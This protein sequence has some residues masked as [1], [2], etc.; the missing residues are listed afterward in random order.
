MTVDKMRFAVLTKAKVAEVHER[1]LPEMDENQILIKQEACNICTT[2]YGQWL[3]LREH[4]PYPMAGGHEGA[5]VIVKKG[6]K[7]RDDLNI[8]DRVAVTYGYCGECGPCKSGATSECTQ[9]ESGPTEDGYYGNFGFADYC[10]RDS[11]VLIK[12]DKGLSASEASF[13]EPLATVAKGLRKLRIKPLETVV[14]IGAGTM[15][16]VN[17]QAAR[18]YGCRVI[19][20][21][22][23]EEKIKAAKSM[24]FEVINANECD[25]VEKVKALTNGEGAD[26]VVVAVGITRANEQALDMVKRVEGRILLFA[27]GYPAP[28]LEIDSNYIHYK[29]LE[30]IGTY[31]ADMQDFVISAKLLN[32]RRVDVSK[33]IQATYPLDKIQEAYG[34]ASKPG[35]YRVS[36]LL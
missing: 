15:G 26:A 12:M 11:R 1:P 31:G 4:Q 7:V 23:M 18:A 27:A 13:L 9:Y 6:S 2:D 29:K 22:V 5:G 28:K 21:E 8:G 14:V 32:E 24:G 25:P 36:V 20:T 34:E 30:L 16:V 19:I 10:V 3:G 33:L 17:A 35:S